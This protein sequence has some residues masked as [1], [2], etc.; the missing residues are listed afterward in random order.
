MLFVV[1][2]VNPST[3]NISDTKVKMHNLAQK[4]VRRNEINSDSL[5]PPDDKG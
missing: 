2:T 5:V 4:R 3:D 1:I